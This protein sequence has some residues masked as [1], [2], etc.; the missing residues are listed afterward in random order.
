[1]V[2]ALCYSIN[3]VLLS[4]KSSK[5]WKRKTCSSSKSSG[6]YWNATL[7]NSCHSKKTA[8]M[9][10]ASSCS[11]AAMTKISCSPKRNSKNDGFSLP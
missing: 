11:N 7:W 1:M 8:R 10:V 2:L 3:V 5:S 6:C 9:T 4:W